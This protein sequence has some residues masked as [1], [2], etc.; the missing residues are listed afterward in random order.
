MND[1][2]IINFAHTIINSLDSNEPEDGMLR[3]K[4]SCTLGITDETLGVLVNDYLERLRFLFSE[5]LLLAALDL[6]DRDNGNSEGF[7]DSARLQHQVRR[8]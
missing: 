5:N 4:L 2:G 8:L 3:C 6:V 7:G 1:V